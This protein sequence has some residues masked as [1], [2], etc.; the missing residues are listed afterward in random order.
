MKAEKIWWVPAYVPEY[1]GSPTDIQNDDISLF[2]MNDTEAPDYIPV[3]QDIQDCDEFLH[4][5]VQTYS[6][7]AFAVCSFPTLIEL[8]ERIEE[9]FN[10]EIRIV[11]KESD[12]N[13]T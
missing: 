9:E 2:C 4:T 3:F 8:R 10:R 6:D 5:L 13:A 7:L 11:V 12:L 1:D